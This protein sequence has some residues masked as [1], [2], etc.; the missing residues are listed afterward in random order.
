[1]GRNPH[2]GPQFVWYEIEIFE[3]KKKQFRYLLPRRYRITASIRAKWPKFETLMDDEDRYGC[4]KKGSEVRYERE[5]EKA[6]V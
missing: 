6:S 4:E 1:M 2:A 5:R 3:R